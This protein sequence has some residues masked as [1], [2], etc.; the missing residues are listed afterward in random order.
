MAKYTIQRLRKPLIWLLLPVAFLAGRPM[1]GCICSDGT[2]KVSCENLVGS[3]LWSQTASR[4]QGPCCPMEI[5]AKCPACQDR[6]GNTCDGASAQSQCHC[7]GIENNLKVTSPTKLDRERDN[8]VIA[9][10]ISDV[11][12]S[13][14]LV[15]HDLGSPWRNDL[16]PPNRVVLFFHLT[17]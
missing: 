8:V 1:V 5:S 14:P 15:S 4:H 16:P 6:S 10:N 17:I 12:C 2:Y 3:L 9:F 7:R 11:R 13:G